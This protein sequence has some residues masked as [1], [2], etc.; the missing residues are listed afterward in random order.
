MLKFVTWELDQCSEKLKKEK[1]GSRFLK[2]D[3]QFCCGHVEP[4][5]P[6]TSG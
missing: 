4:E 6:G 3:S 2:K 5:V 1:K